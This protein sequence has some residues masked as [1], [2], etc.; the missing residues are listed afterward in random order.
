MKQLL[1]TI[2]AMVLVGC[3]ES[4]QSANAPEAQT[5]KAPDISIR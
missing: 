2:A 1:I 3:D 4:Q 5:A